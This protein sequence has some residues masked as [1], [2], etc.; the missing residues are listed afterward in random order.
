MNGSFRSTKEYN[1]LPLIRIALEFYSRFA[2]KFDLG[3]SVLLTT[4]YSPAQSLSSPDSGGFLGGAPA[5]ACD[6]GQQARAQQNQQRGSSD[7]DPDH[8]SPAYLSLPAYLRRNPA[9]PP[10][11][12]AAQNRTPLRKPSCN[13]AL[14]V[15]PSRYRMVPMSQVHKFVMI[16]R[17]D[18][19]TCCANPA[20]VDLKTRVPLM[21]HVMAAR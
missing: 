18:T 15:P 9:N 21:A 13:V 10:E 7:S 20:G 8:S 14:E 4:A 11:D 3:Y 17:T 19:F 16:P 1:V 5:L 6:P 12:T 2:Q